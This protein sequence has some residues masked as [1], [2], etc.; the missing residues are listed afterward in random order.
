MGP[1]CRFLPFSAIPYPRSVAQFIDLLGQ[2]G[3]SLVLP[4]EVTHLCSDRVTHGCCSE[5]FTVPVHGKGIRSVYD[6]VEASVC[7]QVV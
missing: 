2:A 1:N 6:G 5:N 7:K 3:A 4:P